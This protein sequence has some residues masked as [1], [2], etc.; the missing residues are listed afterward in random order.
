MMAA[1]GQYIVSVAASA[2]FGGILTGMLPGKGTA[3]VLLRLICGIF[4]AFIAIC[5]LTQIELEDLPVISSDYLEE[6][7]AVSADGEILAAEV[8]TDIIKERTEAYILDKARSLNAEL[9]V[10]V[11]LSGDAIPVPLSVRLIGSI[12]PYGKSRLQAI[13]ED[14][15]GISKENQIWTG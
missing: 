12:S 14:E 11:T 4:L 2:I 1:V 5:P 10:E 9:T 8:L 13:L 15:L 6:A 3:P 7:E